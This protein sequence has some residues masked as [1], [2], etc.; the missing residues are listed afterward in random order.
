MSAAHDSPTCWI[1]AGPNGAGKTTF[2]LEYLPN[3]VGCRQFVAAAV[4]RTVCFFNAGQLPEKVFTQRGE[5]R[6]VLK[7]ALFGAMMEMTA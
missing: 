2:A 3:A 5:D 7:P 4:S 1:I 6:D